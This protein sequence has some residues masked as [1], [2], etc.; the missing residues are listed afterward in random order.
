MKN[1]AV[2]VVP[3]IVSATRTNAAVEDQGYTYNQAGLT[4]NEAGVM[5]GGLYN[6]QQD[7]VPQLDTAQSVI[8]LI[9]GYQDIYTVKTISHGTINAGQI[10]GPG[11]LMYITYPT[12]LIW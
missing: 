8:P 3:N 7:F 9:A 6:P 4:Y 12:Q 1:Y 2:D 10:M 5:Y 11:F